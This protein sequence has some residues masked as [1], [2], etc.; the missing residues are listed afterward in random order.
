[1][2]DNDLQYTW[3]AI[4]SKVSLGKDT[5]FSPKPMSK[6]RKSVDVKVK[7]H[8]IALTLSQN[9]RIGSF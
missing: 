8:C 4:P 1:M 6:D 5:L 7:E 3:I 2:E 9:V